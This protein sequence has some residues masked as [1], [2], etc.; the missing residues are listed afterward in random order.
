[1]STANVVACEDT[2]TTGKL[3]KLV[4]IEARLIAYH[5]HNELEMGEVLADRV[6]AGE[7]VAVV[8][9]AGTPGISDP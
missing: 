2:R 1:L 8:T 6:A 3:F 9:D 5:D 4:G 7:R